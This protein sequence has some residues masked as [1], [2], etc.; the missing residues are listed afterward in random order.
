M[1]PGRALEGVLRRD[2]LVAGSGL[3]VVVVLAWGYL[4]AGAGMP[5]GMAA[6]AEPM[7]WTAGYALLMFAMWWIMMVA[8]MVP[9][10]AP[11]V[12][13]F[14]AIRR[15]QDGASSAAAGAAVFL[16]GYL[17][18]WAAFSLASNQ[19]FEFACGL[20][21]ATLASWTL[22]PCA[23]VVLLQSASATPPSAV[24]RANV[25]AVACVAV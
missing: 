9:S 1:D 15:G 14:T 10:A 19:M 22:M 12:L 25:P 17:A 16:A 21:A 2:R 6:L 3:A 20:N 23:V 11:T 13:L 4:L 5:A 18:L 7:A 24:P 8:M